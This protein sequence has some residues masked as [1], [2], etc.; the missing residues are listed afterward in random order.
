MSDAKR[1]WIESAVAAYEALNPLEQIAWVV[2]VLGLVGSIIYFGF[3][4]ARWATDKLKRP[5][6]SERAPAHPI[7]VATP[8]RPAVQ[9]PPAEVVPP[10]WE[11]QWE[12]GEGVTQRAVEP[13]LDKAIVQEIQRAAEAGNRSHL[14]FVRGEL[15]IGKSTLVPMV[16]LELRR[17][18][19]QSAPTNPQASNV[20]ETCVV[21]EAEDLEPAHEFAKRI[22][23]A[24]DKD[25]AV[26]ALGRP[27][28][29][30]IAER[31]L[32][33][34]ADKAVTMLPFE[35]TRQL[36]HE[37][38]SA[39]SQKFGLDAVATQKL[40]K[41]AGN[42][43]QRFLQTPFYFEQAARA[44]SMDESMSIDGS[45]TPLQVF[46]RSIEQRVSEL[47]G[48]FA[49]LVQCALGN[50]DADRTPNLAGIIGENGFVHDGYRNVLLAS[51]VVTRGERF[52][53][54]VKC[55]NVIPAIEIILSHMKS[56]RRARGEVLKERFE[57]DLRDFVMGD[58]QIAQAHYP[59][60]IQGRVADAFRRLRDE[61]PADVLRE[62]CMR[63]IEKRSAPGGV[64]TTDEGSLLWDISDALSDVGDPRLKRAARAKFGPES[65]YFV[66][67][68]KTTIEIGSDHVPVRADSAKPVL[69]FRREGVEVGPLWVAKF[70]VTN[71]LFL[72]FWD[73]EG[74]KKHYKATARQWIREDAA[75]REEIARSFDV[76]ATRCFWKETRDQ[77]ALV[78]SG[79]SSAIPTPLQLARKRALAPNDPAQVALWDPTQTD[80]RF[81]AKGKPVVGVN[82]WEAM[83]FCD[84]WTSA[85]LPDTG[86]P[87]GSTA[88]LLTDWE[89][90]AVRRFYY[91]AEGSVDAPAFPA[92]RFPAH[93][94]M[95][96]TS[97]QG[98]RVHNV[99]RPLHVGLSLAPKSEGPTD[100]VGNVWEWTRSRVF[101]RIVTA[102]E[103]NAD[104][105][106][107]AWDDVDAQGEQTPRHPLRDVV[108]EDNDL[109]YRAVRGGSFFSRDEQAAW[110]PAYRLCDPPFSSYI[111]LGFRIAVYLPL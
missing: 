57:L 3:K 73:S 65:G 12:V 4:I 17:V 60:F 111:D 101:G 43:D 46:Q 35:P 48:S 78:L 89:W 90:E 31:R 105:G 5:R 70:L 41:L 28:T 95:A 80:E 81:S 22:K 10:R 1:Q 15:G 96:M 6:A 8:S 18:G 16:R 103:E 69:P 26:I 85:K 74:R 61:A 107:T 86:F 37:C 68:P 53:N 45:F 88:G 93:T 71:E 104:F 63:M 7:A 2:P 9:P 99:L 77:D 54:V 91:E 62:R 55:Q 87:P 66:A 100:M 34:P 67:V 20:L 38:I 72:E 23:V 64:E 98:G 92:G 59:I 44:I 13:P 47:G 52:E 109:S 27:A 39:I 108:N 24:I 50:L 30:D 79:A 33:R 75:L 11:Y 40:L 42:F 21:L 25:G 94:R 76:T 58:Q 51:A 97:A 49:D 36:F 82:W 14:I 106:P 110:N 19:K 56:L 84:W 32:G 83:A 29:M 102:A